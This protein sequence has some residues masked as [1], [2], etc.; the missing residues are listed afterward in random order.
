MGNIQQPMLFPMIPES[1]RSKSAQVPQE[2]AS[3]GSTAGRFF[4]A[5][6]ALF[7]FAAMGYLAGMLI[8]TLDI[9]LPK[10]PF[11]PF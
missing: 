10:W 9:P 11:R 7:L 6:V 8:K 3:A 2:Q 5:L 1:G 4:L